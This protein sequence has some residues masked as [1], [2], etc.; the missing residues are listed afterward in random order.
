MAEPALRLKAD[1]VRPLAIDAATPEYY[2]QM[3][4]S[5][6]LFFYPP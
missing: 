5:L 4:A 2:E 1:Y 6:P 3:Y